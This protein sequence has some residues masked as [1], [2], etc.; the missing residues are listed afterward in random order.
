MTTREFFEMIVTGDE[1]TEVMK[2]YATK[3]IQKIDNR[4]EKKR[5]TLTENQTQNNKIRDAIIEV[6]K[7]DGEQSAKTLSDNLGYSTQKISALITPLIDN[8]RVKIER[9][10]FAGSTTKVNVY[11]IVI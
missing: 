6:L 2:Q 10:K 3:Q 8:G 1:V 4:N 9:K 11:S 5:T 7:T